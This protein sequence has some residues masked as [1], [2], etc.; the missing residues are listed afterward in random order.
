MLLVFAAWGSTVYAQQ[1][2]GSI[3][4]SVVDSS[5]AAVVGAS[6]KLT[7][8]GTA[9]VQTTTTDTSG[10][11]QFLLLQPGTYLIEGSNTGFKTFRR[12]GIIVEADRSLGVPITLDVGQ[13]S[14]TVEVVG[15]TPLL[16]P[17]SSEVGTTVD[18]QKV[19]DL[20]LNARNPMGL[21]NL[22][23]T[24]KGVGYFGNQILT[25][26]RVGSIN[27]GGGQALTSAFLLDGVANDKMGD[28]SGANTFLTTDS[29]GEFKIVTNNMSA[30]YGRTT[31]GVI[32]I[33]SK[34]GTNQYHGSAFE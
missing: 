18:S 17:N 29:T 4:G 6:V 22:I 21:A 8:T 10:N 7:N 12:D 1:I 27:I 31:G 19:M 14:E 33:I 9:F 24:V 28:A 23:P 20:P 32:S 30:V 2:T 5:G 15:G 11:F 3:T 26:W 16:E 34:S 25:S 13:T